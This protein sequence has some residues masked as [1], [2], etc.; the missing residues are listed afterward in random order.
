MRRLLTALLVTLLPACAGGEPRRPGG[1]EPRRIEPEYGEARAARAEPDPFS[2]E[3]ALPRSGDPA[4]PNVK[5]ELTVVDVLS[6][7]GLA[8][9]AGVR[10]SVVRGVVNA[11]AALSAGAGQA[12]ARTRSS[13]FIVVQAGRAGAISLTDEARRWL[14]PWAALEVHV[15]G[16]GPEGVRL[17]VGPYVAPA[18]RPGEVVAG[19]TEVTLAPGEAVLL[20][21]ASQRDDREARGLGGYAERSEARDLVVLLHVD[22]LG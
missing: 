1:G 22:V 6:E 20:G 8:V 9:R 16:A 18:A 10:G 21:G 13:T 7:R 19:G 15:L 2:V 14:G 17:A 3:A 11:R 12:R 5:V 4:R